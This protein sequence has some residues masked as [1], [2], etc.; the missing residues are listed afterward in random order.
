MQ[1]GNQADAALSGQ[2]LAD[3]KVLARKDPQ[4]NATAVANQFESL[5]FGLVLKESHKDHLGGKLFENHATEL[6]QELLDQEVGL[7]VARSSNLGFEDMLR[8]SVAHD[9][10]G[11]SEEVSRLPRNDRLLQQSMFPVDM[12]DV[13]RQ[14]SSDHMPMPHVIKGQGS[15]GLFSQGQA[16]S[17]EAFVAALQEP[18]AAVAAQLGVDSR[19]L[20]AQAALE[21]GWG[22]R[23]LKLPDGQSS[24]NVFNIKAD[25][26]WN[27]PAV[28][29]AA[30]EEEGGI[31]VLRTSRF[32]SYGSYQESVA[33]YADFLR[34]NPRYGE[35]LKQR[36][37]AGY[38][39]ALAQAGYATDHNYVAKVLGVME[40]PTIQ[41]LFAPSAVDAVLG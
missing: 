6:A 27:G 24:F 3:L 36:D 37:A 8:Q 20:M 26:S 11:Q 16:W 25:K 5:L 33:D 23:I 21:S 15:A 38:V 31:A 1:I 35:A 22:R 32:R 4:K 39:A 28:E 40:H 12:Q 14:M 34:R 29:A 30:V 17:R 13:Q 7:H 9:A 41:G 10:A 19:A 18:I 2:A